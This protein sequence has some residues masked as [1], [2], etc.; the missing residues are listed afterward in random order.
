MK[1]ERARRVAHD[2]QGRNLYKITVRATDGKKPMVRKRNRPQGF[3]ETW[4]RINM[5]YGCELSLAGRA[6]TYC[7]AASDE[8]IG[9]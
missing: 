5:P 2:G 7:R 8:Q 4:L 3:I 6:W 9:F 1:L